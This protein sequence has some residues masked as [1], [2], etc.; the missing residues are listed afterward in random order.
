MQMIQNA[1]LVLGYGFPRFVLA[2]V[3]TMAGEEDRGIDP[4]SI[5]KGQIA[6]K[7]PEQLFP[8]WVR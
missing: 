8:S 2:H 5:T 4:H 3:L 6:T 1:G 7:L